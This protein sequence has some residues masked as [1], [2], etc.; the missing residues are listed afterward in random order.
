M[1]SAR[2][3]LIEKGYGIVATANIEDGEEL[4]TLP[5]SLT[6]LKSRKPTGNHVNAMYSLTRCPGANAAIDALLTAPEL[7]K[8]NCLV[9]RLMHEYA[10]ASSC[11][12][13]LCDKC[14][15]WRECP[16]FF[17]FDH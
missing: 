16:V 14:T 1:T 12:I 8:H 11:E 7:D 10:T 5:E 15:S 13:L 2:K 17:H 6:D 3:K 9:L 4:F